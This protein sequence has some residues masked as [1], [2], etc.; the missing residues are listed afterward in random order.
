MELEMRA[1]LRRE[2]NARLPP[3]QMKRE[4]ATMELLLRKGF[5]PQLLADKRLP[6]IEQRNE[7]LER[8]GKA[9]RAVGDRQS[10]FTDVLSRELPGH[11]CRGS[12]ELLRNKDDEITSSADGVVCSDDIEGEYR[13]VGQLARERLDKINE[14]VVGGLDHWQND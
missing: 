2:R 7:M 11:Y 5:Q 4:E 12:N 1:K 8:A 14:S 3:I 9:E 10:Y 13:V 6:L